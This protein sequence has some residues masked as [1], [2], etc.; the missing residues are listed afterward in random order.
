[1][2]S[3]SGS[4]TMDLLLI[5]AQSELVT[6]Y[7]SAISGSG[8]QIGLLDVSGFALANT[9][10]VNYG[11]SFGETIGLLD[12]GAGVT[13]FVVISSGEV[14]FS[15]D[16]P[17]GGFNYTNEIHKEMAITLQEAE[18]MKLSA[19]AKG[20]V[21]DEVHSIL[22]ATNDVVTRKSAIVSNFFRE[23]TMG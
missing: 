23:A 17:V 16:V 20:A 9:F 7:A 18:S 4:D 2:I 13:N 11:K 10:E 19:V 1:M 3:D 5:A 21:P 6:Q 12:I 8:L 22:S 15:R 14:I